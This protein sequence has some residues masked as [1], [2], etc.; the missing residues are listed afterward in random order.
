MA[1]NKAPIYTFAVYDFYPDGTECDTGKTFSITKAEND[2]IM[3]KFGYGFSPETIDDYGILL[4]MFKKLFDFTIG[5]NGFRIVW[6]QDEAGNLKH[7][8]S[9]CLYWAGPRQPAVQIGGNWWRIKRLT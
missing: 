2:E 7:H 9:G 6:D 3:K 1:C 8:V 5:P 4:I